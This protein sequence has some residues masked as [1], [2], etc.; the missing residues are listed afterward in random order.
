VELPPRFTTPSA[1]ENEREI[2]R[3]ERE[4]RRA[5]R[6]FHNPERAA[7]RL[8]HNELTT[9]QWKA[10]VLMLSTSNRVVGIEGLAG[11]GKSHMLQA[12]KKEIE[13]ASHEVRVLAP[14]GAQVKALRELGVK[15]P[16][17]L[18]Y[19][20]ARTVHGSQGLTVDRV[21][22]EAEAGSPTTAQDTFYVGLSRAR[23]E[24]QLFTDDSKR[25]PGALQRERNKTA[26]LDL[27][28]ERDLERTQRGIGGRE[29]G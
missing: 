27:Q 19:G 23:L 24:V 2:L 11:T 28:R 10:A 4:G 5:I 8:P 17:H 25:L 18:D 6:P 12:A 13:K 26:A 15:D 21:I 7:H 3:I 14:Y 22:Y 29:L 20:Y 9:E 16:L 1:I